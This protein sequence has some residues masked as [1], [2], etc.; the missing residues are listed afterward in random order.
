MKY[1][2]YIDAMTKFQSMTG[3]ARRW[4]LDSMRVA[5]LEM[6]PSQ[7]HHDPFLGAAN[8]RWGIEHNPTIDELRRVPSSYASAPMLTFGECDLGPDA[9]ECLARHKRAVRGWMSGEGPLAESDAE[10]QMNFDQLREKHPDIAA[11][12]LEQVQQPEAMSKAWAV[13]GAGVA[14]PR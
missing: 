2:E 13:Q 8:P 11:R 14:G 7:Y 9:L 4:R 5:K 6:G 3:V 10:R 1:Q 12:Y